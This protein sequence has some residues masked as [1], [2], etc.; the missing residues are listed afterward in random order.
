MKQRIVNKSKVFQFPKSPTGILGLD[1]ITSGG[2]PKNRPTL[3]LG[4][5]GCGKTLL[6][7]EFLVKGIEIYDEHSVFMSFEENKDELVMNVRSL[8]YDLDSHIANNKIYIE[9]VLINHDELRETGL[10]DLEGLFVRLE[11]A[12][13]KVKAKRVVLDSLDTLFNGFDQKI[14]RSEF[15]RLL[16]WLKKIEVTAIITSET[17]DAFLTR[18]GMEE[19]VADCVIV[20]D[21]RITN[22]VAT[23][24]LRIVKY[25][26]SSH[27]NNE[28]PFTIDEKGI[29]VYPIIS[30]AVQQESSSKRISS[31]IPSLDDMLGKKGFYEGSSIL[32]SGTAGTGKTSLAASFAYYEGSIKKQCLFCAFE[33]APN[34]IIRNMGSIGIDLNS[35]IK[36]G[37]LTFYYARPTLQ[38]LELHFLAIKKLINDLK[39]A[40]VILDPI[41][42]LMTEGPNS[43]I[44]SM[45]TRFVDFLK[46]QRITVMFTAAI[47]VGSIERNPSDE[48]ISSMVDTWIM[49]QDIE[50]EEER[51]RSL[52][53]MKS[54]GM[55][56]SNE[57]RKFIISGKGIVLMPIKDPKE[58]ETISD[59]KRRVKEHQNLSTSK[60]SSGL[61]ESAR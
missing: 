44:R 42:N 36:S 45:L 22:Q 5:T 41:T 52:C 53:V 20:L 28:Y 46:T 56:H 50:V 29:S 37:I 31:G 17:G 8:G 19:Y 57:V 49:V 38:N 25:R 2:I 3:L 30:V 10:Y 59:T 15:L 58:S 51:T 13:Y 7:M 33:E 27:G 18:M 11:Q 12:I 32:I 55:V 14:L 1:E 21:N 40:V 48:G 16:S 4:N 54:R 26:G 47:T 43:D 60:E 9:Q 35:L 6:A 39:P 34:Q 61:K 23:R 24:R